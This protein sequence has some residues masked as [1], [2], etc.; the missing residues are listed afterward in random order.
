MS[1]FLTTNGRAFKSS[2]VREDTQVT[3]GHVDPFFGAKLFTL[4]PRLGDF[5]ADFVGIDLSD[6][7]AN[8]AVVKPDRFTRFHSVEE[9]R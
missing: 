5:D 6:Y 9:L 4:R 8:S 3:L 1:A 2:L 7:S